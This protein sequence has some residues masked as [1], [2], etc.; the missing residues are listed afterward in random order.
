MKKESNGI[1]ENKNSKKISKNNKIISS[2]LAI[3]MCCQSFVGAN[4]NSDNREFVSDDG[5]DNSPAADRSEEDDGVKDIKSKGNNSSSLIR[6]SLDALLVAAMGSWW[7]YG[8]KNKSEK[9]VLKEKNEKIQQLELK[10]EESEK[11]KAALR[12]EIEESNQQSSET[13]KKMQKLE[14]QY[15]KLGEDKSNLRKEIE[16]LNKQL[17]E[18]N[19]K[20]QLLEDQLEDQR[21]KLEEDKANLQ[22][23]MEDSNQQPSERMQQLEQLEQQCAELKKEK[24]ALQKEIDNHNRFTFMTISELNGAKREIKAYYGK[25]YFTCNVGELEVKFQGNDKKYFRNLGEAYLSDFS[26]PS[27]TTNDLLFFRRS[28]VK[29]FEVI[30]KSQDKINELSEYSKFLLGLIKGGEGKLRQNFRQR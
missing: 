11:E 25:K 27:R 26:S 8:T 9:S 30:E 10:R 15:E 5:I 21:K 3:T 29:I 22:K 6:N 19:G 28:T 1:G 2:I 7:F 13:N 12:K 18:I 17:S 20:A 23:E 4:P 14:Q 16:E 24:A